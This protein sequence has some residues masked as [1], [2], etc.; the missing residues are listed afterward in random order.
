MLSGKKILLGVTGS[1]AAYKA[2]Y[3]VRALIKLEAEVKV[4]MTPASSG[5]IAPLTLATLAKNPVAIDFVKNEEEGEWENH[6]ELGLWADLFII[7]PCSANTLSKLVSGN[8]D[9]LLIATYL[10][11]KCPVWIAPAMDLDMF[12]HFSTQENLEKLRKNQLYT[13]TPF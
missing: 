2:A 7:A 13:F 12:A 8:C 1:I 9:N 10:S 11:A 4:I 3:L 6:V 5:F